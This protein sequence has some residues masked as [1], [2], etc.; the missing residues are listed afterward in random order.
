VKKELSAIH[1]ELRGVARKMPAITYG[2]KNL[3]LMNWAMR[4]RPM[5]K[6]PADVVIDGQRVFIPTQTAQVSIRLRL[7]RPCAINVPA[8][9]LAQL[10]HDRQYI[11]PVYRST[12]SLVL[13]FR[14]SATF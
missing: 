14:N 7:Y 11:Q 6:M 2:R 9:A 8:P 12:S 4:W 13:N 5:P 1:P 10:A 3:W